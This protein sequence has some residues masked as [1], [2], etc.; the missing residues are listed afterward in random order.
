[1]ESEEIYRCGKCGFCLS[2]C[3]VYQKVLDEKVSPRGKVQLI[4]YFVEQRLPSTGYLKEIVSKCLMCGN[5]MDTCPSGLRH[6]PLF[7]RMRSEMIEDFGKKWDKKLLSHFLSH[8]VQLRLASKAMVSCRKIIHDKLAEQIKVGS[9][10]L[11]RLPQMNPEPFREV[12]PEY[13]P[14][15]GEKIGTIV[16]FTGCSTN[17]LFSN[18][19]KSVIRVLTRMG[20]SVIVPKKQV[21]CGLPLFYQGDLNKASLN[22]T[23][24]IKLLKDDEF[25]TVIV[26][27]ATCGSALKNEYPA[28]HKCRQRDN[29][30]RY[31]GP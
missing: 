14:P 28:V 3:P 15:I 17:Y 9:I 10:P 18:V 29:C 5:C 27:C 12:Y 19:G 25:K 13:N 1:M 11:K 2:S 21:C 4:K 20:F 8:E 31:K 24:N 23:K 6:A 30:C 22:I 26:D 7:M 16:Y